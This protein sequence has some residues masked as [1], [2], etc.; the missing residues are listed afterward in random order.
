MILLCEHL[1]VELTLQVLED[2]LTELV[3]ARVLSELGEFQILVDIFRFIDDQIP[4]V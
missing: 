4:N 2:P 1:D 3:V